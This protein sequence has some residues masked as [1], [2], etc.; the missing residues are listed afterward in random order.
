MEFDSDDGDQPPV[1]KK[2]EYKDTIDDTGNFDEEGSAIG[3]EFADLAQK[4]F[5][6][7]LFAA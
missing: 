5:N 4:D 6:D 1:S 7:E 2:R 3:S